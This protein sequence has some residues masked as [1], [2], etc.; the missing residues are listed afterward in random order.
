MREMQR[1]ISE[2][3]RRIAEQAVIINN[4]QQSAAFAQM[5]GQADKLYECAEKVHRGAKKL[6]EFIEDEILESEE[7]DERYG[8]GGNGGGTGGY[9]DEDD[10]DDEDYNERRGVPGTGRYGRR[11]YGRVRP[12]LLKKL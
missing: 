4:A 11:R 7:F 2:R 5:I 8:G 6:M 3:D 12:L 10:D 1:E 9:R